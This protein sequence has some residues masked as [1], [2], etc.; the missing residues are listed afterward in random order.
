[1]KN[2]FLNYVADSCVWVNCCEGPCE[3]QHDILIT[4]AHFDCLYVLFTLYSLA[5]AIYLCLL[6]HALCLIFTCTRFLLY[7]HLHTL[8]T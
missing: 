7:I 4:C 1:M 5:H 6:A 8:Y 2:S 3:Q